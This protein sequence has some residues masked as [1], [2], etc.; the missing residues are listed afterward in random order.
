M[1]RNGS[2]TYNRTQ[3]D[4]AFGEVISETE[5][6]SELNDIA[7]ALT[8]SLSKDGQTTATGNQPM[9]GFRH[10]GV[11]AASAR[12]QYLQVGQAQ[13][14]TP[15]WCGTAGGTAD[16]RTLTPTPAITAYAAG[17]RWVFKN[18]AAANTTATPTVT[19]SG[20]G[21]SRTVKRSDGTALAPGDMGAN[22]LLE[23]VDDGTNLLLMTQ[24]Y[25]S[26]GADVASATTTNIWADAGRTLHITGNTTITSFGTAPHVGAW[27]KVIF[28][29]TLTLTHGAN[30]NLPGSANITTAAGD[31]AFVYAD[32]TTQFDVLYSRASGKATIPSGMVLLQTAV[33]SNSATIDLESFSSTYDNYVI[34]ANGVRPGTD[35]AKLY[36]RVKKSGTYA[37]SGYY[38]HRM[39]PTAASATYAGA[40]AATGLQIE[41]SGALD[42]VSSLSSLDF[43]M[44]VPNVNATGLLQP[45]QWRGGHFDASAS[46]HTLAIGSG[47]YDSAGTALQGVRFLMETGNI[48]VGKFYLYGIVK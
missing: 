36:C 15:A 2:G 28:D 41:I 37:G 38:W 12:D 48:A 47:A 8:Q 9:G 35:G 45:L 11:G 39:A 32:T 25:E 13:D 22:A 33:A 17:Q 24:T 18:G 6:N 46:T 19:I 16:A 3:D 34:I 14:G 7:A 40:A 1:A 21:T 42:S 30:L 4:Y 23:M 27:K 5:V 31:M 29:G 43:S 10:T 26:E 44:D 20:L